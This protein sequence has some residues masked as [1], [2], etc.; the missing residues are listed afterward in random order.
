MA[1][2][3]LHE[4]EINM[5]KNPQAISKETHRYKRLLPNTSYAFARAQALVPLV[6]AEMA[7]AVHNFPIVFAPL[8]ESFGLMAML[9]LRPESNLYIAPDGRWLA[10]YVPAFIR[11]YPFAVGLP[12]EGGEPILCVD[13]DSN[14]ISDSDGQPLFEI[15]GSPSE[16]MRKM[17]EFVSE[18][19][20]NRAATIRAV[21]ALSKHKLI[22]P[23]EVT[24]QLKSGPQQINGLFKI[25]EVALNAL[26]D[27]AFL[28][29][30]HAGA[31]PIVYA[32]LLS[33]NRIDVIIRLATV[34]A[35][36]ST[37]AAKA[38]VLAA[39][40]IDPNGDLVFDF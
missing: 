23:W 15:D 11:Q 24:L 40:A 36:T 16:V 13:A 30:R 2:T 3:P 19:E 27:D 14:L 9:S 32:H 12:A 33:L 8:G 5:L 1:H 25:D 37:P 10:T 21:N 6:G 18:I 29:V 22:V 17:M 34:Q 38:P 4:S 26:P 39:G 20:R 28:E 35:Q 31:M 7:Q